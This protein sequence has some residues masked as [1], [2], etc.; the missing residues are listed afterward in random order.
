MKSFWYLFAGYMV[1]WSLIGGY[2]LSLGSRLKRL[3]RKCE[4][5]EQ[6]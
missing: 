4:Q 1:I 3:T 2:M 5:L 6:R